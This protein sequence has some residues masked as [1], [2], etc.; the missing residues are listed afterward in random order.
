MEF[1]KEL[2]LKMIAGM[3]IALGAY[4]RF[5]ATALLSPEF[6]PLVHLAGWI[7]RMLAVW[8]VALS[9][10]AWPPFLLVPIGR[11]LAFYN[12]TRPHSLLGGQTPDQAY[13]KTLTPIPVAA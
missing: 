9:V 12:G 6:P 4:T 5:I 11:Y 3:F 13:L 2:V 7:L 1:P 10:N 8:L